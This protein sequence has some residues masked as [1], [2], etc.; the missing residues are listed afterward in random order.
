MAEYMNKDSFI[1][2]YRRL[3]CDD[4][5][6]RKGMKRGK[7]CFVYEIGDAPC[8]S[9]GIDD[10]IDDMEDYP[11]I[12]I[13]DGHGDLIDKHRLIDGILYELG[14]ADAIGDKEEYVHWERVLTYV[15]KSNAIIPAEE[16][17]T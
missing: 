9:C 2:K 14:A 16:G 1:E 7:T 4:C 10:V 13:P 5:K 8:R 3:Y 15:R 11:A 17:E 12:E 6:R